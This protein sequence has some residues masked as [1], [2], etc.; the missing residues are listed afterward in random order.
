V[1]IYDK[2]GNAVIVAPYEHVV[3]L[4]GYDETNITYMNNGNFFTVPIDVFLTS[5]GVL[6]NMAVIYD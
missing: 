3:I 6:G 5:W 4:I 2:Q 1:K